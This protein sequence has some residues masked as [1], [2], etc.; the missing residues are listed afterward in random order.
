V[1]EE[2][3]VVEKTKNDRITDLIKDLWLEEV[4]A[5]K[6]GAFQT[7]ATT[8]GDFTA[9]PDVAMPIS[10][11]AEISDHI[12]QLKEMNDTQRDEVYQ[13]YLV[14][15]QNEHRPSQEKSASGSD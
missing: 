1:L 14:L 8:T 12:R 7:I 2:S 3:Q 9:V 13:L 10:W 5:K 11:L 4:Q 15:T 6:V